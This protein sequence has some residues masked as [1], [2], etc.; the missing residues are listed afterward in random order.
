MFGSSNSQTMMRESKAAERAAVDQNGNDIKNPSDKAA[1][2]AGAWNALVF[3]S[4][5]SENS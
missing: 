1:A 3:S 4:L 5:C 2:T